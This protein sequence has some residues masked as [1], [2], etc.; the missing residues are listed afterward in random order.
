MTETALVDNL[1][2]PGQLV[3]DAGT[4]HQLHASGAETATGNSG[5][6]DIGFVHDC[7][8]V[9][10]FGAITGTAPTLDLLIQQSSDSAG[11]SDVADVHTF[12]QFIGTDDN[13]EAKQVARLD[14]RYIKA[15]WTIGGTTPSFIFAIDIRLPYDHYD[16]AFTG[17]PE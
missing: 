2:T 6:L 17:N 9:V 3:R 14:K 4:F 16:T 10:A 8:I 12:T 15:T 1:A 11:A 5:W 7:S 13:F